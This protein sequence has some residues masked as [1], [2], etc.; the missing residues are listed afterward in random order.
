MKVDSTQRFK[1]TYMSIAEA[2]L[3]GDLVKYLRDGWVE[4]AAEFN[5]TSI[6]QE[7]V[8]IDELIRAWFFAP[9]AELH[10]LTP[11][12]IIRNEELGRPNVVPHDHLDELF[13][14]DCPVC[15]MMREE[16]LSGEGGEWHFGLAPDLSLLD[17]YD[18][19]GYESRWAELDQRMEADK[20][21]RQ[22][23]EAREWL[24][25]NPNPHAFAGN[26]FVDSRE[27]LI[28]VNLLYQLD[29]MNVWIDNIYDEA[30]R[31]EEQGG[32][33]ADTF[34]VE[35]PQDSAAR[36]K[37]YELHEHELSDRQGLDLDP[38]IEEDALIFWWD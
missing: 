20:V 21:R 22:K 4:Q 11:R 1:E 2:A 18:P 38:Y 17:E 30:Y 8:H 31:I 28:F 13:F 27:A 19:E 10:G 9:Q 26:R 34:I 7:R 24:T 29:A 37:L 5:E 35:L 14:D 12:D 6:D 36:A 33:Y 25:Q 23:P 16:A 32:P 3:Y 15:Q